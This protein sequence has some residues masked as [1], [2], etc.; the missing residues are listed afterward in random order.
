MV[1]TDADGSLLC[2]WAGMMNIDLGSCPVALDRLTLL[3]LQ[4]SGENIVLRLA[5]V[6]NKFDKAQCRI[7]VVDYT[8]DCVRGAAEAQHY[9]LHL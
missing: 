6:D 7:E 5:T 8:R 2:R 3:W 9:Q 4:V 1:Y